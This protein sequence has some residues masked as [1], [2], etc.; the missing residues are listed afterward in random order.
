MKFLTEDD[1]KWKGVDFYESQKEI[2]NDKKYAIPWR[3]IFSK[4]KISGP[5]MNTCSRLKPINEEDFCNRAGDICPKL[6]KENWEFIALRWREYCGEKFIPLSVFYNVVV[7]HNIVETFRGKETEL[8]VANML[9]DAGFEIVPTTD[10]DDAKRGIDIFAKK[11]GQKYFIQVKVISYL[12]GCKPDLVADRV[13]VFTQYIPNQKEEYGEGIPYWWIFYDYKTKE[14]IWNPESNSF[15]WDIEKI[16]NRNGMFMVKKE[17]A[18]F[19]KDEE[20][21]RKTLGKY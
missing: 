21:R 4:R 13:K 17:Y 7:C 12:F 20:F 16:L 11:D 2:L 18:H 3:N 6:A 5:C 1:V 9:R 8:K 14:W 15:K 19:F 10:D